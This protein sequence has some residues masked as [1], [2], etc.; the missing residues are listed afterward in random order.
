MYFLEFWQKNNI[1]IILE[2]NQIFV[3]LDFEN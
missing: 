1:K 3:L 2:I